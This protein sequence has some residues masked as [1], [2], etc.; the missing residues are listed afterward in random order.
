MIMTTTMTMITGERNPVRQIVVNASP[1]TRN[2][3]L[4]PKVLAT[5]EKS[6][7]NRRQAPA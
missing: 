2:H 3:F 5:N 7:A 1:A 4:H 6:N